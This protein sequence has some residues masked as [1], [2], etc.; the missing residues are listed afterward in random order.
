MGWVMLMLLIYCAHITDV[1]AGLEREI[2]GGPYSGGVLMFYWLTVMWSTRHTWKRQESTQ[3]ISCCTT[4][5]APKKRKKETLQMCTKLSDVALDP[6]D[7][8][9]SCRLGIVNYAHLPNQAEKAAPVL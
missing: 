5:P 1:T 3:N 4:K 7:G 6:V 2:G 8:Q 9:L